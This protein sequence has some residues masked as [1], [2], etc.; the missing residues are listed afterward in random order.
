MLSVT[1]VRAATSGRRALRANASIA[2]SSVSSTEPAGLSSK[3]MRI[4]ANSC[5]S[6]KNAA[7]WCWLRNRSMEGTIRASGGKISRTSASWHSFSFPMCHVSAA[8]RAN[9]T[10]AVS[11]ASSETMARSSG[12]DVVLRPKSRSAGA[13]LKSA[14]MRSGW[15]RDTIASPLPSDSW[16]PRDAGAGCEPSAYPVGSQRP[17][18]D[19]ASTGSQMIGL[20]GSSSA[21]TV[22]LTPRLAR[23]RRM[24]RPGFRRDNGSSHRAEFELAR[25]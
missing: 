12:S 18:L 5:C 15:R 19:C 3:A 1:T 23:S 9:R 8:S 25:S 11:N 17:L 24:I 20:F 13:A 7:P 21:I 22:D 6:M 14:S 16:K 2:W 4:S 10:M